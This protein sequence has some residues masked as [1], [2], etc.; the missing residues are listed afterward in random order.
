MSMLNSKVIV[1][2]DWLSGRYLEISNDKKIWGNLCP[3]KT[4]QRGGNAE[5]EVIDYRG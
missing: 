2:W 5:I 1:L 4:P 3:E